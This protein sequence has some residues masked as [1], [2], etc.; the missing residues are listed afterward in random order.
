MMLVLLD[1]CL[2]A[3]FNP[4]C[5]SMAQLMMIN[6]KDREEFIKTCF[7]SNVPCGER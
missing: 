1:Y 5:Y 7:S 2:S 4:V 6:W 3:Q